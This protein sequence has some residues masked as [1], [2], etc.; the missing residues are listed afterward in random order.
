VQPALI[1]MRAARSRRGSCRRSRSGAGSGYLHHDIHTT[2]T[3]I[4][5]FAS[6]LGIATVMSGIL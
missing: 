6:F 2:V 4:V 3:D 5:G 1:P